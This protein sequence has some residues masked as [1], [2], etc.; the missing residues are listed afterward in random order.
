[1]MSHGHSCMYL[2]VVNV[3]GC[4][5]TGDLGVLSIALALALAAWVGE[6]Q[7]R[8]STKTSLGLEVSQC[9]VQ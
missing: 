1:M 9:E 7:R 5:G 8:C 3:V 4:G 6:S 2:K